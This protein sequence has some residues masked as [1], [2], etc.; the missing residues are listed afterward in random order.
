M[1]TATNGCVTFNA[2]R[3]VREGPGRAVTS[4]T[5]L[6]MGNR[7]LGLE[8]TLLTCATIIKCSC[9][10][11]L[12]TFGPHT[13]ATSCDNVVTTVYLCPTAPSDARALIKSFGRVVEYKIGFFG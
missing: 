8:Y 2:A 11:T 3:V 7:L 4:V 10:L 5:S 12:L 6:A 1:D 13:V 9:Q